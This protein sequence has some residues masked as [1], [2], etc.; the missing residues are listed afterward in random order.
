VA[1]GDKAQIRR[2]HGAWESSID[3]T[4][5]LVMPGFV[6]NHSHVAMALLRGLA[7]DLPLL[8]WL[9]EKVWPIEKK[10]KPRQIE[11]GAALGAAE[12]LLSG[13]TSVTSIYFYN[14]G[15]S[16][17]SALE[18][19][20]LRGWIAHGI[21]DWSEKEGFE[22][23]EKLTSDFHGKDEGRIRVATSPHSTYS[24]SPDLLK[25]IEGLRSR[26]NEKFGKQYPILNTIH[27]AEARTEPQEI[28]TRYNVDARRG[29]LRYLNSL[30]VLNSDTICAH[31]IHL[32]DEDY[33]ALNETGASIA[34]CPISNLKVGCGVA[35][36][37]RAISHGIVLSFGTDGPA[38][39]NSLDMFETAKM[40]SLL[41]KG[42]KGDPTQMGSRQSFKIATEGGAEALHQ[43]QDIGSIFEGAK[44]DLVLLDLTNVSAIPFHDPY[45]YIMYSARSSNVRDVMVDGRIIV[46]N[47]EIL[48]MNLEKLRERISS[49]VVEI[50]G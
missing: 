31:C 36:L 37:P 19:A 38:S 14:T 44:A 24:C 30:G 11:L 18:K 17:A 41:A 45:N 10:L 26:L 23:T 43:E 2:K 28:K 40:A 13:T 25:K 27:V 9:R 42:L 32:T 20:G 50:A 1:I 22:A 49:A 35:D 34:S 16:E 15:G 6:N 7:E 3:A 12:A 33:V 5:C 4:H 29:I 48:T 21:F 46:R 39:N 8:N 47:G